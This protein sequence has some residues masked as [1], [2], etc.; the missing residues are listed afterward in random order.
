MRTLT[1]EKPAACASSGWLFCCSNENSCIRP[2]ASAGLQQACRAQ[3][4]HHAAG[5][6]QKGACVETTL[7]EDDGSLLD[8]VWLSHKWTWHFAFSALWL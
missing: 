2:F 1:V 4:L 6:T 3:G 7:R 5:D 8:S